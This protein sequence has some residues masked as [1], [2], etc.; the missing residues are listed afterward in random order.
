[1]EAVFE[2][3]IGGSTV[4]ALC[5]NENSACISIMVGASRLREGIVHVHELIQVLVSGADTSYS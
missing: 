1:M 5:A 3:N 4:L 2:G